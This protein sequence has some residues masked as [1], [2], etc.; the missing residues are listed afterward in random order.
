MDDMVNN[1]NTGVVLVPNADN[2]VMLN[3]MTERF[4][5]LEI[6]FTKRR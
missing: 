2:Y 5:F 6:S 1:N 4:L 3:V